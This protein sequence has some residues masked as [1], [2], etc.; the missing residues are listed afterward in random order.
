MTVPECETPSREPPKHREREPLSNYRKLGCSAREF[1]GRSCNR[2]GRDLRIES[3]L[4][5]AT[6][7]IASCCGADFDA[8]GLENAGTGATLEER[9]RA[10]LDV[11]LVRAQNYA[12]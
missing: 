3:I 9:V 8:L 1:A 5:S 10:L 11:A 7:R 12:M 2:A 4:A 6:R